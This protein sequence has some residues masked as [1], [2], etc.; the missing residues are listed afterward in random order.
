LEI[1]IVIAVIFLVWL[2]WQ[3][4]RAKHFT[5]FK[6]Q[7]IQEL[8]PKVIADIIEEMTQTRSEQFPNTLAHQEATIN[9]WSVSAGRV[10]QAALMREIINEPWLKETGNLRN[11]Q[12]LFHIERDKLHR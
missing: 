12:H 6:R 11:S 7:I 8:K 2:I 1:I 10:L 5:Q 4:M 9:Y 3:L